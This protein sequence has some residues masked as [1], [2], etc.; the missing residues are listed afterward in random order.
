MKNFFLILNF[1]LLN[2]SNFNGE[3]SILDPLVTDQLSPRVFDD[4]GFDDSVLPS[5]RLDC[6]LAREI[7]QLPDCNSECAFCSKSFSSKKYL[8]RHLVSS[9]ANNKGFLQ[10]F[11]GHGGKPE[12]IN[13]CSQ[14]LFVTL[15]KT[16]LT[17]HIARHSG[18]K[19]HN[20]NLCSRGFNLVNDLRR[21]KFSIHHEDVA[22]F[23]FYACTKCSA[24]FTKK[25]LLINHM[26][27]H[28]KTIK[29]PSLA[30]S[31]GIAKKT[32]NNLKSNHN[33][34]FDPI[35]DMSLPAE[36]TDFQIIS[37]PIPQNVSNLQKTNLQHQSTEIKLLD[38]DKSSVEKKEI[39]KICPDCGLKAKSR[40]NLLVHMARHQKKPLYFCELC[41][42]GCYLKNDLSRHIISKH[43]GNVIANQG[44]VCKECQLIFPRK[45]RLVSHETIHRIAT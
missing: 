22:D 18:Q 26:A 36:N 8:L 25:F 39:C 5:S 17:Q 45:E 27:S 44:H 41:R 32:K 13:H 43:P 9:H 11:I 23:K 6:Y 1:C 30:I 33:L 31:S 40:A 35:P 3:S 38:G 29:A 7:G 4:F 12:K 2:S 10:N 19:L 21:H 20:C 42:F 16:H 15:D 24:S 37:V 14:C 28:E 34:G